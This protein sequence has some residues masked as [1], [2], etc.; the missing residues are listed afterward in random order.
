MS[1]NAPNSNNSVRTFSNSKFSSYDGHVSSLGFRFFNNMGVIDLNPIHPEFVGKT[2]SKG[3]KVYSYD[4]KLSIYIT[5]V[6]AHATLKAIESLRQLVDNGMED[7]SIKSASASVAGNRITIYAPGA[8][9]V[10][11]KNITADTSDKYVISIK[12]KNDEV[13]NHILQND[14]IAF[15]TTGK[16]LLEDT[17]YTGLDMLEMFLAQV[18]DLSLAGGIQA[19]SMAN[20]ERGDTNSGGRKKT[21][22]FANIGDD[23]EDDDEEDEVAT[24]KAKG[25]SSKKLASIKSMEE[26]FE[27]DED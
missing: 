3:D 24:P 14:T 21:N 18:I 20:A 5:P 6:L 22:M 16:N 11:S 26:E 15:E 4:D 25:R 12:T 27:E 13:A 10:K 7:D 19:A 23:D 8:V 2:P 17:V 9:K 1:N